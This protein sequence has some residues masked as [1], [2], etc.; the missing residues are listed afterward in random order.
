MMK[1]EY[2]DFSIK[3]FFVFI[4]IIFLYTNNQL[5]IDIYQINSFIKTEIY[6]R[7]FLYDGIKIALIY[8]KKFLYFLYEGFFYKIYHIPIFFWLI[9][10]INLFLIYICGFY[11]FKENIKDLKLL[12]ITTK[13]D[14]ISSKYNAFQN[15]ISS[16]YGSLSIACISEIII[17]LNNYNT[18]GSIFW[19]IITVLLMGGIQIVEIIINCNYVR[20]SN[21]K[22]CYISSFQYTINKFSLASQSKTAQYLLK[23]AGIYGIITISISF[24]SA[25]LFQVE[26]FGNIFY[27]HSEFVNIDQF[28]VLAILGPILLV[29]FIITTFSNFSHGLKFNLVFLPPVLL[30][31]LLILISFCI[32][33][34]DKFVLML[35]EIIENIFDINSIMPGIISGAVISFARYIYKSRD[36]KE[37]VWHI[38]EENDETKSILMYSIE[39]FFMIFL[40]IISGVSYLIFENFDNSQLFLDINIKYFL[41]ISLLFFSF[42]LIINE[43]FYGRIVLSHIIRFGQKNLNFILRLIMVFGVIF[44]LLKQADNLVDIADHFSI[45]FV[46]INLLSVLFIIKDLKFFINNLKNYNN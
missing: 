22:T 27:R 3:S 44:G 37:D 10:I 11:N 38:Y 23:I 34:A 15:F 41:I 46:I 18:P 14:S 28:V 30:I 4:I 33:N 26:Q 39:S 5:F 9:I 42:S 40:I 45:I 6:K 12:Y 19:M 7:I 2:S 20:Q 35:F 32:I 31:Y 36:Y 1:I 8:M 21:E 16:S 24:F 43:A 17:L 13:N 25:V 29:T